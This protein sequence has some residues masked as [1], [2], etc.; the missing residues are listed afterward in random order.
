VVNA[1]KGETM[2]FADEVKAENRGTGQRC[3]TCLLLEQMKPED[4]TEINSVLADRN[5]PTEPIVRA[6]NNRGIDI[7]SS[8]IRKHRLRC[9]IS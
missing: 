6:L 4:A 5:V 1:A 7:G 2:S 9:V 3:R 8:A